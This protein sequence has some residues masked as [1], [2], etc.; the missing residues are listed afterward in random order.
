MSNTIEWDIV[1]EWAEK[2]LKDN[3]DYLKSTVTNERDTQVYRGRI[4]ELEDLLALPKTL[5][6]AES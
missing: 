5:I 6:E 3:M 1:E 4:I 2:R